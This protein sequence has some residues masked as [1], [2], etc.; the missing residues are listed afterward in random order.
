MS[1]MSD[2]T[3]QVKHLP[4]CT[5]HSSFIGRLLKG[6]A[7]KIWC[8]GTKNVCI[9]VYFAD[10]LN[11]LKKYYVYLLIVILAKPIK[12]LLCKQGKYVCIVVY[13]ADCYTC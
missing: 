2:V 7:W 11:Q 12:N 13:F 4:T 5:I 3:H 10:C 9:V 1:L 8:L 6:H